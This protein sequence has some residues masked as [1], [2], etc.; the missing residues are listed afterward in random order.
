M[1]NIKGSSLYALAY[2]IMIFLNEIDVGC[3]QSPK[4][5]RLKDIWA[6]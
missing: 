5:E 3:H 2:F 6:P 1:A 4:R